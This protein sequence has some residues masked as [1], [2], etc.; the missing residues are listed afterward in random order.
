MNLFTYVSALIKVKNEINKQKKFNRRFLIPYIKMLEEKYEGVFEAP[1]VKKILHYY[2][3]FIP[4]V[5]CASYKRL[6]GKKL[7]EEERKRVT[8]FGILTPVGDDLFDIDKL[9]VESI[10]TITF[11]PEQFEATTFTSKVAKEIQSYLLQS[12]PY[13]AQ[14]VKA[15]KDVFEIQLQTIRQTDPSITTCEIEE[16]TY[17]KGGYSVIIYHQTLDEEASAEM[18]KALFNIGSLM[19]FANDCFDIYKD[20]Q[21]G[22]Y[23]LASRCSDYRQLKNTYIARVRE[24][25]RLI[26]A[27]PYSRRKKEE[28][29]VIMHAI[30]AQGLAAID[31]MLRLQTKAGSP[32]DCKTLERKELICDM[33]KPSNVARWMYYAWLLPRLN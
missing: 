33:Q 8:L 14:Y 26:M 20:V 3:L 6:Y 2:G 11:T 19:Q 9:D 32:V 13:Q 21:D 1:Q 25:N 12:V 28:F 7:T 17:A 23:T 4:S 29:C 30:I 24:T 31:Q 22:I 27:L 5:L 16:I 18:L 10:R 15:A